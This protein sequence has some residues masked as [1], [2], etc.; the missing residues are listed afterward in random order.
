M[1]L[2]SPEPRSS[3]ERGQRHAPARALRDA[4]SPRRLPLV[5]NLGHFWHADRL[6][7]HV[8][9]A[10]ELG[11][12]VRYELPMGT[13][14]MLRHPD[15]VKHV[16]QDNHTNYGKGRGADKLRILLGNG[17]LTSEGDFWR[18][19]RRLSQPAFHRQRLA[20]LASAMVE[21]AA[22]MLDRWEPLVK[23]GRAFDV[24]A[25]MMRVTLAIAAKTLFG[26]DVSAHTEAVAKAMAVAVE[27]LSRRTLSLFD[28]PIRIPT[29]NNVRLRR[30]IRALDGMVF[31]IIEARR[32]AGGDTG[33][34][35]S[36][37]MLAKDEE[38]GESMTDAQLRD[39]VMT[40]ILAGHETTANALSWACFLLSKHPPARRR[41]GEELER[42][43]GG[44][45][46][47]LEDL[48][49]LPYARMVIEE[50][51]R[52][53]P[54]AWMIGRRALGED[55]AGGYRIPARSIV[56]VSPYLT[57]RHRAYWENPE[58]FD[59]ERFDPQ[60]VAA[61]PARPRYAYFPFGGGPRVCIGNSF[62]LMEAHLLLATV[63]SRCR[64]D[65]VPA[66]P[67]EP[68]PLLTLRPRSGVWV[69]AHP[70]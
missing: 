42:V 64:L 16:L 53:Y 8:S 65:L 38:T 70:I 4:P 59:P 49:K 50:T 40:L 67:V 51:M 33:N 48:P 7:R 41:L 13:A 32:R 15:H 61:A 36:M 43:L 30:A 1:S 66:L 34:L 52:L 47:T 24:A 44:R 12:V 57:H 63:A 18:R 35:L 46:P 27:D 14:V 68:A 26:V 3:T 23:S 60:R 10:E 31:G 6:S 9:D 69:T 11:D 54:P 56:I 20:G 37:L 5:G 21:E 22:A 25:E 55:E 62:A 58:G 29:P 45:A 2:S 19:Q 28:V 39:E 17:L